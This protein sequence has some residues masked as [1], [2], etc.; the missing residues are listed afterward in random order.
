M[1]LHIK[2][3]LLI[4]LI[5]GNIVQANCFETNVIDFAENLEIPE[6]FEIFNQQISIHFKLSDGKFELDSS[7]KL[8]NKILL[9]ATV[10]KI[11]QWKFLSECDDYP[12]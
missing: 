1:Q 7:K 8:K 10:D 2:I 5:K 4:L 11:K 9:D 12:D 6:I 3:V